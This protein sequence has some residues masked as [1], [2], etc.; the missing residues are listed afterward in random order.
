MTSIVNGI[1]IE[2][3]AADAIRTGY[4]EQFAEAVVKAYEARKVGHMLY[5]P[6]DQLLAPAIHSDCL[7]SLGHEC[8]K[9]P[10]CPT[11]K[12]GLCYAE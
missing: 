6:L 9:P 4:G 10:M 2:A 8:P 1:D 5:E 12:A 7:E 11:A 3:W